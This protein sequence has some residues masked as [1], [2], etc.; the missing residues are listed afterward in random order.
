MGSYEHPTIDGAHKR[1]RELVAYMSSSATFDLI[2]I[3]VFIVLMPVFSS[4]LHQLFWP[5]V[6]I[7]PHSFVLGSQIYFSGL[8]PLH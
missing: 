6:R 7:L 8:T 2:P 5:A 3:T 4:Q 1:S